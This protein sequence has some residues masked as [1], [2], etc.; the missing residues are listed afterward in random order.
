MVQKN[1]SRFVDLRGKIVGAAEIRMHLLH[2][3]PVR[4]SDLLLTGAWPASLSGRPRP[5]APFRALRPVEIGLQD[6]CRLL[7]LD[8]ALDPELQEFLKR[9]LRKTPAPQFTFQHRPVHRATLVVELH[10]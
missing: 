3:S 5:F 9:Q 8:P 6:I 7:I 1:L 10:A 2:Q 4:R